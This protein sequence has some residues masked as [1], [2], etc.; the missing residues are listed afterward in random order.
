M[1]A[2]LALAVA[3][4]ATSW[5][6]AIFREICT[7][8]PPA[9]VAVAAELTLAVAEAVAAGEAVGEAVAAGEAV[10]LAAVILTV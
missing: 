10:P 2:G 8:D 3:E 5:K 4:G 7:L 6:L 1:A 9:V